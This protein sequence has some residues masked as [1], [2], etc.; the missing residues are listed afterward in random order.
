MGEKMKNHITLESL[1]AD[2]KLLMEILPDPD[3]SEDTIISKVSSLK[4]C[5][6]MYIQSEMNEGTLT[7]SKLDKLQKT[8]VDNYKDTLPFDGINNIIERIGDQYLELA[9]SDDLSEE[10]KKDYKKEALSIHSKILG[11]NGTNPKRKSL[12]YLEKI[13]RLRANIKNPLDNRETLNILKEK[14]E[15]PLFIDEN[16]E[17]VY[18]AI[19]VPI[20]GY[21]QAG[22]LDTLKNSTILSVIKQYAKLYTYTDDYESYE[23]YLRLALELKQFNKTN[24]YHEIEEELTEI[25]TLIA[26]R[27][28]QKKALDKHKFRLF[29]NEER[30]GETNFTRHTFSESFFGNENE[31]D[32]F[33]E[34]LKM[35]PGFCEL[36]EN[37]EPCFERKPGDGETK[38]RNILSA[39][40]KIENIFLA[41]TDLKRMKSF[42]DAAITR[43]YLRKDIFESAKTDTPQQ[44][45][46]S[47]DDYIIF[48]VDGI[49]KEIFL[50]ESFSS[51]EEGALFVTDKEHLSSIISKRRTLVKR[52][53][54]ANFVYHS[55][56]G[57]VPRL[58]DAI[59]DTY[60]G[61]IKNGDTLTFSKERLE[62]EGKKLREILVNANSLT[63]SETEQFLD[64]LHT[65]A[66][67]FKKSKNKTEHDITKRIQILL[68][69]NLY[70]KQSTYSKKLEKEREEL[71]QLLPE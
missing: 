63:R 12:E 8:F 23:K 35:Y 15:D 19:I 55:K 51:T 4:K 48:P 30:I 9:K 27:E 58:T 18:D 11:H 69:A 59:E 64:K 46:D 26:R 3:V 42:K 49:D 57:Y 16:K 33:I 39:R 62:A 34:E 5:F 31:I 25:P 17:F 54:E 41:L 1:N 60:H 21:K 22:T 24:L 53:K 65:T 7:K 50:L 40:E 43:C 28:E 52:N 70:Q 6:V 32:K 66:E 68:R 67:R 29:S 20:D 56:T 37:D 71:L 2:M 47:F 38:P 44:K 61:I 45:L 36:F 13:I 10:E 14:M